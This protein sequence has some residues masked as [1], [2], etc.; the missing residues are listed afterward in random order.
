MSHDTQRSVTAAPTN[1]EPGRGTVASARDRPRDWGRIALGAAVSLVMVVAAA[2][3]FADL[4][5]LTFRI[6]EIYTLLYTR[7]PWRG[8]L[9][10]DGYYD[11]HPPLYY[12]L[13]K[14]ANLVVR[15]EIAARSVAA[16]FGFLTVPLLFV[17]VTRLLDARAG[18]AAALL[19]AVAPMHIESS[20]D[21]RMYTAVMFAVLLSYA[22]LLEYLRRPTL[23]WAAAY[24]ASLALAIYLDYTALYPLVPQAILLG[25]ALARHPRQRA[26]L[27]AG[28]AAAALSYLPWLP[29]LAGTI[30]ALSRYSDD[31]G[32]DRYLGASWGAIGESIPY[33]LGLDGRGSAEDGYQN[34]WHRWPDERYVLLAVVVG[35]A[36]A[37]VLL[38]RRRPIALLVTL[39]LALGAPLTAIAISFFTPAYASRTVQIAVIGWCI[40]VGW[41]ASRLWSGLVP[42]GRVA[43]LGLVATLLGMAAVTVPATMSSKGRYQWRDVVAFLEEHS[44]QGRPVILHSNAGTLTDVL[45]LYGGDAFARQRVITVTDGQA[46]VFILADR[47]IARGPTKQQVADGALAAL[48]PADDPSAD[49]VW[50]VSRHK[51]T[52][53]STALAAL[54]YQEVIHDRF[55][56]GDVRLFIRPFAVVG[57]ERD[58]NGRFA[59]G[60]TQPE[61]W[62]I[63]GGY[64]L[65][66]D[67]SGD[68]T[69]VLPGLDGPHEVATTLA[70]ASSGI[71]T[72]TIQASGRG[73]GTLVASLHCFNRRNRELEASE[74]AASFDSDA[75]GTVRLGVMCPRG[76]TRVE[77]VLR[78]GRGDIAIER[79]MVTESRGRAL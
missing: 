5:Y 10:L 30:R 8:V 20:R 59:R 31:S 6:D 23:G 67:G 22:F 45:D 51:E 14:L 24:G 38:M 76:T 19:L 60:A 3:R 78:H 52:V 69:L 42:H 63:T 11:G 2:I 44:D 27:I 13:A 39:P 29:E 68:R 1:A 56:T 77:L 74:Q 73:D 33:V 61:R 47:W 72:A 57:A 65:E 28:V 34:V 79:V 71:Y 55:R 53:I 62:T 50:Y 9:G 17:L 15:E 49:A 25:I 37:G 7:Q 12:V 41:L 70:E 75:A 26:M 35:A 4:G 36:L 54:G 64:R 21:G 32:R 40:A 43:T 58:V 66:P 46:E 48:L 18:L 16:L